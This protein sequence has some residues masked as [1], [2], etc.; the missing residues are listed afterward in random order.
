MS[1]VLRSIDIETVRYVRVPAGST[2]RDDA[3]SRTGAQA[4]ARP[5]AKVVTDI[6]RYR[7]IASLQALALAA[8][9]S[10]VTPT[11]VWL[12]L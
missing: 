7:T 11:L 4:T 3:A 1:V 2:P 12:V 8:A 9:A 10:V 5:A 6:A